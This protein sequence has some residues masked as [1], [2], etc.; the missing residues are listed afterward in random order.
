M[1][2][3]TL[4]DAETRPSTPDYRIDLLTL[5]WAGARIRVELRCVTTEKRRAFDYT[6]ATATNLMRALNTADLT[7]NSL[8]KRVLNRLIADGKLAGSVTGSPD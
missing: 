5:D 3:L 7:T 2:H 4:T 6:G 8:H 1:E